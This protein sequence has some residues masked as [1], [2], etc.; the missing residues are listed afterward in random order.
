MKVAAILLTACTVAWLGIEGSAAVKVRT[1]FT[2]SFDFAKARTWSWHD[3]SPGEVKM[4][5]TADDDPEVVRQRAEPVIM[6]AVA[7]ALPKRGLTAAAAGATADLQ[8]KYY[9][10]ITIGTDAQQLGQFLPAV[11]AWG[12]PPFAGATQSYKVIEQGSLVI[13]ISANKEVVWRG[14]GQAEL[15]PGQTAEKRAALVK[16]AVAEILKHYPPKK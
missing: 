5:R 6:E 15:K 2:K 13:D 1:Q 11:T 4:A 3:G 7:A 9:V 12:L 14:I 8:V 16:E 10:L